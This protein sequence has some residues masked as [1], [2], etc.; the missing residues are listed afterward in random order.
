MFYVQFEVGNGLLG[1]D[2][3]GGEAALERKFAEEGFEFDR[4]YS[5]EFWRFFFDFCAL[6]GLKVLIWAAFIPVLEGL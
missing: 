3:L 6:G 5:V 4:L 1:V 2:L